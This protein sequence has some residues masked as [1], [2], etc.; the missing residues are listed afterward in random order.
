MKFSAI[1]MTIIVLLLTVAPCCIADIF[2][3]RETEILSSKDKAKDMDKE[4]CS[5]FFKCANCTGFSIP[6]LLFSF[7]IINNQAPGK[8]HI[9]NLDF[10]PDF[11]NAIWQP[12][13]LT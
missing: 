12:P 11:P 8:C 9:K 10:L 6:S 5:P 3:Q 2:A 1:L 7:K 13:K 4:I